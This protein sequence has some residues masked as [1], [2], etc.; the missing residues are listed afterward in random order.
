[1]TEGSER[2][3]AQQTQEVARLVEELSEL[4]PE[5]G[6]Y[7]AIRER[8]V[9]L[10]LP[11]LRY[12]ARRLAGRTEN[13]EDLVQVGAIGLLKA[14]DRFDVS[15]GYPF[16]TYAAPTIT[17]EMKRHLRDTGWLVRVPRRA[18]ELHASVMRAREELSQESGRLPTVSEIAARLDVA[19]DEVAETLDVA[20]A[21]QAA[22]LDAL[23]DTDEGPGM[24]KLVAEDEPGF[25]RAE[26]RALLADA[27]ASLTAQERKVV[28]LR[29]GAS[30]TQTEIAAVLKVS[31]MQVSRILTRSV[32]KMRE[33]LS[34][35]TQK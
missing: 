7:L 8:I 11:L 32:S 26:D 29:F 34:D 15:L 17:G 22:P 35:P 13:F 24:Q 14:I 21:Q 20:R 9:E 4:E 25:E 33:R 31:Q 18:Q 23:L 19:P 6:E 27:L 10:H 16:A 30:K 1:M 5:T 12:L 28:Q 2:W 3:T